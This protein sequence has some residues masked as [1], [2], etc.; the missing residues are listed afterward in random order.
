MPVSQ[1]IVKLAIEFPGSGKMAQ[2]VDF[3]QK[4]PLVAI[5]R[6]VCDVWQVPSSEQYALQYS[7]NT[8]TYITEK[9]RNEIKN[10]TVLKLTTSPSKTAGDI[11]LC[12]KGE[13]SVE[14]CKALQ[15][16]AKISA[17][18]TFA[19]EFISRDGVPLLAGMVENGSETG[20]NLAFILTAFLEL[21]DHGVVS[22]DNLTPTFVKRVATSVNRHS[23]DATILQKSLAILESIALNSYELYKLVSSEVT[24]GN[25][26][27]HIQSSNQEIQCNAVA[28]INALFLRA[29]EEKR[30]RAHSEADLSDEEESWQQNGSELSITLSD[31][32]NAK[33]IRN[34]ILNHVIRG[35]RQVGTEM[36]HQLYVH[37]TL[38]FN[39]LEER[40]MTKLDQNDQVLK[41]H[42]VELRKVAF[43]NDQDLSGSI[44]PPRKT[45]EKYTR[46]YKKLGFSNYTN[47]ALDFLETPPGVLAL[48]LMVY[49][50]KY[51][52]EGYT[53]LVLENSCRQDGHECAFGKSSIELTKMLCKILKVGE[54]PTETGQEYYPMFYTHDHAFEEFFCICIQLLNKTWKEMRATHEDFNKVMDV[55][56]D[57][58]QRALAEK[59]NS[60]EGFKT[61]L[62]GLSYAQIT[63]MR[64]QE[65]SNK[66]EW[67]S[68]A[69]PVCELREQIK[70]EIIN[71]VK[72]QRLNYL[73]EGTLFNKFTNRRVKDKF[74]YCRL[75][76]NHKVL[77][78]GDAE[79]NSNPP[80][81]M[82]PEKIPISE[83][84]GIVTGKD[85][86]H[87][88]DFRRAKGVTTLAFAVLYDPDQSLDFVAPNETLYSI[89]T[90]GINALLEKEMVSE[91]MKNDVETLLS[92]DMK[93]RLLDTENVPIPDKPPDMPPDPPNFDFCYDFS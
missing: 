10:G 5:I 88:K 41:D 27:S 91:E 24:F 73:V 35:P 89:W 66:E 36:A 19:S 64:I 33:Q 38:S 4:K 80:I 76:P 17:D 32:L 52:A 34:V 56:R 21:M 1:D 81:E 30:K 43:D 45:A 49:F 12:M 61:K 90:D 28:L 26:I 72:Q 79:E 74:W 86:P 59:P 85:C 39:L 58:I 18:V 2:L 40:R 6:D 77:H 48:D 25:L 78:Y 67:D 87:M 57:Q 62:Q 93:L 84:K 46:D 92:M 82:L 54:I 8:Q 42:L 70:P 83:I 71:L 9:N 60:L 69:R 37:Q 44:P 63:K 53:K 7:D 75:S 16:L 29:P 3:D 51:H 55:V 13:D 31:N 23:A 68:Q 50:A 22:W 20:E 15:K 65:R 14:K 11:V 47:P